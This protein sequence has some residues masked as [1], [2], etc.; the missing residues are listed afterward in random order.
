MVSMSSKASILKSF[1]SNPGAATQS[2]NSLSV[3][4]TFT[5]GTFITFPKLKN[6]SNG[7]LKN[8]SIQPL[9]NNVGHEVLGLSTALVSIYYVLEVI[10]FVN[11]GN[12]IYSRAEKN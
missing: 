7:A 4:F 5:A 9:S 1:F 2:L 11:I 10:D 6:S 3:S 8:F 12:I